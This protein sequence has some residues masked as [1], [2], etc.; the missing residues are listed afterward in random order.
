MTTKRIG[1]DKGLLWLLKVTEPAL[2]KIPRD[3]LMPDPHQ[4]RVKFDLEKL[5]GL[6]KSIKDTGLQQRVIVNPG[7]ADGKRAMF[8]IDKGQRRWLS[9]GIAK[10]DLVECIVQPKHYNADYDPDRDLAQAAENGCREP[11]THKEYVLLVRRQVE[12]I[13]IEYGDERGY[14][15]IALERINVAFGESTGFAEKYHRLGRLHD[16]FLDMLDD[17]NEEAR[18]SIPDGL[19]LSKVP[20]D[21]Q[22]DIFEKGMEVKR[23]KG[24][25]AAKKFFATATREAAE[26]DGG[27]VRGRK[28]SDDKEDLERL[29]RIVT[30]K[31]DAFI[32]ERH[33]SE[34]RVFI[35]TLIGR[36]TVLEVDAL[37]GV[38]HVLVELTH[39]HKLLQERRG[40]LYA[41]FAQVKRKRA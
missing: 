2:A 30:T 41:P 28:P 18:L 26:A 15:G 37:L 38:G 9:H 20:V 32:G 11:H 5:K 25:I 35:E 13:R 10:I 22:H 1:K 31:V 24:G 16:S 7:Y 27:K 36:L 39:I 23:K 14:I 8:Y 29:L 17:E 19:S 12:A 21:E 34:Y 40:V 4:P 3:Q 33:S 6:A